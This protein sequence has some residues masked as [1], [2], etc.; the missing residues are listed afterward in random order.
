LE[1]QQNPAASAVFCGGIWGMDYLGINKGGAVE[2]LARVGVAVVLFFSGLFALAA[3]ASTG[4][5]LVPQTGHTAGVTAVAFRPDADHVLSAALD[6][7]AILWDA[8]TGRQLR[9]YKGGPLSNSFLTAGELQEEKMSP[10]FPM[11][12]RELAIVSAV[13]FGPGGQWF[14]MV[15]RPDGFLASLNANS[16]AVLWDVVSGKRMH[17]FDL[18]VDSSVVAISP[19]GSQFVSGGQP[20]DPAEVKEMAE[21]GT[22]VEP[23]T[24]AVLWDIATGKAIRQFG[25]YDASYDAVQF[26]PSG[27]YILGAGR[28]LQASSVSPSP[29]PASAVGTK[30]ASQP[31]ADPKPSGI[32]RLWDIATG[33]EIVAL[34][35]QDA[36]TK[37]VFS[38]SGECVLTVGAGEM[39]EVW[40]WKTKERRLNVR[41]AAGTFSADGKQVLAIEP[42]GVVSVWN[43]ADGKRVRSIATC[44]EGV[45]D[46][47]ISSD[48]LRLL[49]G[50]THSP[51]P[52]VA[53]SA[54]EAPSA[55][56]PAD[57]VRGEA[58]LFDIAAGRVVQTFFA[59]ADP[60]DFVAVSPTGPHL[61]IGDNMW[62]TASGRKLGNLCSKP[63]QAFSAAFGPQGKRVLVANHR[64]SGWGG[65]LSGLFG[66]PVGEE[67][68]AVIDVFDGAELVKF[69]TQHS[70]EDRA[71]LGFSA[72]GKRALIALRGGAISAW[73]TA[74]GKKLAESVFSCHNLAAA[75]SPDG[76]SAVVS[77]DEDKII[78]WDREKGEK[79]SG[80][81]RQK[82][83]PTRPGTPPVATRDGKLQLTFSENNVDVLL[84][85]TDKS[86]AGSLKADLAQYETLRAAGFDLRDERYVFA[87]V[88][89]PFVGVWDVDAGKRLREFVAGELF[90]G[91]H[92]A[93]GFDGRLAATAGPDGKMIIWDVVTGKKTLGIQVK[94]PI[95][96]LAFSPDGTHIAAGCADRTVV[97]AQIA[98]GQQKTL[99]GHEGQVNAV[100]FRPDGRLLVT[101][102]REDG[103]ARIWDVAAGKELARILSIQ[104]RRD[105]LVFTPEGAYDGSKGGLTSV[106]FRHG[107]GLDVRPV[108]TD[109]NPPQPGLLGN[110]WAG[111]Q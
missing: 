31:A 61:L 17:V 36:V 26:S 43:L 109:S 11:A 51:T 79:V 37:A 21:F 111:K 39:L 2:V 44:F 62:D 23:S 27:Q 20:M 66:P 92:V 55:V 56:A 9:S 28:D 40:D 42:K 86:P 7:T 73:D 101:A 105:W 64:R 63:V 95:A 98:T 32:L 88:S 60:V 16:Q 106:A 52:P 72:D 84:Q 108:N 53:A 6:G 100:V 97:V 4:V 85:H 5:E 91:E 104:D 93:F 99:H 29:A 76:K 3:Q 22:K 25:A 71:M 103:T 74:S 87:E 58:A 49:V 57:C 75:F 78:W 77:F 8:K 67:L 80:Q 110:I 69:T 50:M 90:L 54:D 30:P 59:K 107:D 68:A 41:A 96:S 45:K 35:P 83:Q 47:A 34:R 82:G 18:G 70:V 24:G 48:G 12:A 38:P 19:D 10:G 94:S 13:E 14:M 1:R 46:L 89:S 81:G 102:C 65:F 15:C 33:R